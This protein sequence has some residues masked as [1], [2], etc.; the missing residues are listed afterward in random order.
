MEMVLPFHLYV[1]LQRSNSDGLVCV[2]STLTMEPS[3]QSYVRRMCFYAVG[4]KAHLLLCTYAS[5]LVTTLS[6]GTIS[7]LLGEHS[8]RA[9]SSHAHL[10]NHI[11]VDPPPKHRA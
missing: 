9:G 3:C 8:L 5:L 7:P 4:I 2:A 1:Q 6:T 10:S 11:S